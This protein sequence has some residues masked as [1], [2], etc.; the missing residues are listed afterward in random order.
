MKIVYEKERL[1]L[2]VKWGRQ[3]ARKDFVA[4]FVLNGMK[5]IMKVFQKHI[6]NLRV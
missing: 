2:L 5:S 3:E 4:V 6:D 1:E